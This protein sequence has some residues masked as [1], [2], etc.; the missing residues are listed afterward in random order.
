VC[1]VQATVNH[2]I[3]PTSNLE[4]VLQYDRDVIDDDRVSIRTKE[5]TRFKSRGRL[6]HVCRRFSTFLHPVWAPV[7][8]VVHSDKSLANHRNIPVKQERLLAWMPRGIDWRRAE[9]ARGGGLLSQ[10][11]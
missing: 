10:T 4:E 1:T 2:R 11:C 9:A 3:H 7:P 5:W 6:V 8:N